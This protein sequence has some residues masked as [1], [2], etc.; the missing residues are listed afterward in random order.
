MT[1]CGKLGFAAVMLVGLAVP[2]YADG[3]P[4]GTWIMENGKVTVKI[5]PCGP[6]L[7]G[8]IV[9]LKK[10]LDKSGKPKVDKENPNASLRN[11]PIIG[12]TVLSNM[13]PQSDN[14]WAGKIYNADDGYTYTS[15]M[16]LNGDT[17]KVKGCFGPFCKSMQF[18]RVN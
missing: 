18:K 17:I 8:T 13:V 9:A 16:K 5:S 4:T 12:I 10:P 11:R 15:Y 2:S 3:G 1:Y 6:N 14:K 7:C